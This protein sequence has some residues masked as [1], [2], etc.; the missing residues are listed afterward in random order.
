MAPGCGSIGLQHQD[1]LGLL[2]RRSSLCRLRATKHARVLSVHAARDGQHKS[3]SSTP[4]PGKHDALQRTVK[5]TLLA[6]AIATGIGISA[7]DAAVLPARA[8]EDAYASP[9]QKRMAAMERRKELLQQA[10]DK[11][12]QTGNRED[13]EDNAE[14]SKEEDPKV[15]AANSEVERSNDERKAAA[16][17]MRNSLKMQLSEY[18][19]R[20]SSQPTIK[21][22]ETAPQSEPAK[23][24]SSWFKSF[25]SGDRPSSAPST[26]DAPA[27]PQA[28]SP[29]APKLPKVDLPKFSFS[30]PKFSLP[31]IPKLDPPSMPNFQAPKFEAP[32][33]QAPKLDLPKADV[34]K[35]QIPKFEAPKP[36]LPKPEI[37]KA[38]T[39]KFE[40]PKLNFQ[41]PAVPKP[42]VPSA[43]EVQQKAQE[44]TGSFWDTLTKTEPAKQAATDAASS[45]KKAVEEPAKKAADASKAAKKAVPE[46][47]KQVAQKGKKK[48]PLPMFLAQ[49]LVGGAY[50]GIAYIIAV[51]P[52]PVLDAVKA[53]TKLV[54]STYE[55][56]EAS[57]GAKK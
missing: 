3:A 22:P 10:R 7:P 15:L 27:A 37:P 26:S 39:P 54:T 11:A 33:F 41:A 51:R 13:S 17:K 56:L 29:P 28:P 16:E 6:A 42:D 1:A 44:S 38:E 8:D 18:E 55:K 24:A 12:M 53:G 46:P 47:V 40:V 2:T 48:G 21:L 57:L 34:P 30:A 52:Q 4:V 35:P 50:A 9:Y 32:S 14:T 20:A 43:P 25:T 49:I 31:D 5:A 19:K 45:A 23:E 36:E